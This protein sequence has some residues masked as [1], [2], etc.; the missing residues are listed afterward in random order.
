MQ[1][2]EFQRVLQCGLDRIILY[3][4]EHDSTPYQEYILDACLHNH[5]YDHQSE[6]NKTQYLYEIIQLTHKES[7]YREAILNA[8]ATVPPPTPEFSVDIDWDVSQFFDFGLIFAQQGDEE[9]RQAMYQLFIKRATRTCEFGA[10]ELIDLDG[11]DGF[12]FVA[13]HLHNIADLPED[14]LDKRYLETIEERFGCGRVLQ[15]I[16]QETAAEPQLRA[17]IHYPQEQETASES[18]GKGDIK[19]YEYAR[20]LIAEWKVKSHQDHLYRAYKLNRL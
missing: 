15:Y 17:F 19:D 9:A 2:E 5:V 4:H 18:R 14:Q 12:L 10:D 1:I 6:G 20:Q 8:M 11:L 3:L 7:F 13:R 16:E